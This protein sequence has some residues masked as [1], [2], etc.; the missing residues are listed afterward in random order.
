MSPRRCIGRLTATSSKPPLASHHSS[1]LR[2]WVCV[3]VMRCQHHTS[4][5]PHTSSIPGRTTAC[6]R[7]ATVVSVA[8]WVGAWVRVA[9]GVSFSRRSILPR[10]CLLCLCQANNADV[11]VTPVDPGHIGQ[12]WQLIA[13]VCGQRLWRRDL[14]GE[15][16][17]QA[18]TLMLQHCQ[19]YCTATVRQCFTFRQRACVSIS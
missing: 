5:L 12:V 18:P 19:F 2:M 7:A 13:S 15:M 10:S 6:I 8:A 14:K 4:H 11:D 3:S 16:S 17:G 9:V 1:N